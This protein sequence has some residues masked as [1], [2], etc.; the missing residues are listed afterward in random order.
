MAIDLTDANIYSVLLQDILCTVQTFDW[1]DLVG[2]LKDQLV[3]CQS[4]DDLFFADL[5]VDIDS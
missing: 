1:D 4:V 2:P 3:I 5:I